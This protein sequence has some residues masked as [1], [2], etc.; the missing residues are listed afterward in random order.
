[1]ANTFGR[2]EG[3]AIEH[4]FIL[5]EVY[6]FWLKNNFLQESRIAFQRIVTTYFWLAFNYSPPYERARVV[7]EMVSRLRAWNIGSESN[8]VLEYIRSGMFT[9]SFGP[10]LDSQRTAPVIT[11]PPLRGWQKVFA[12]RNENGHHIVR[13][14]TKK[15]ASRKVKNIRNN[16]KR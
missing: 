16:S 13:L 15:I 8:P 4:I 5:D 7:A 6:D 12:V 9:I 2:Q 3:L 10:Q 11:M 14:F 1:M